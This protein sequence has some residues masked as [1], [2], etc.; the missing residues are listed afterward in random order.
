MLVN[1]CTLK[2]LL[3]KKHMTTKTV[4]LKEFRQNLSF[5]AKTAQENNIHFIVFKKNVPILDVKPIDKKALVMK[6][7]AKEIKL[8]RKQVKEGD[9]CTQEEVMK[10]FNII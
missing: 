1:K 2:R 3:N 4:G 5:Y 10:K 9:I 8:A 7:L 6:K